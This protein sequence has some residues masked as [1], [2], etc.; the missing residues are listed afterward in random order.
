MNHQEEYVLK[1]NI[2]KLELQSYCSSRLA[3]DT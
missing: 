2:L 1:S 3:L